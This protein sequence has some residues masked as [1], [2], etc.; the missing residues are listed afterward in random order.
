[1][2]L[3]ELF[4]TV[5]NQQPAYAHVTGFTQYDDDG[6]PVDDEESND[7]WD[8]DENG[9]EDESYDDDDGLDDDD[10]SEWE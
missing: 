6:Y 10:E 9:D 4:Q 7:D 3:L 2:S 1:M 5:F 8:E